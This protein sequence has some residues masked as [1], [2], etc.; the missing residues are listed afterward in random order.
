MAARAHRFE[1]EARAGGFRY[2]RFSALRMAPVS[3]ASARVVPFARPARQHGDLVRLLMGNRDFSGRHS[4]RW[5]PNQRE[6][7]MT[8]GTRV[9]WS[10]SIP[11]GVATL[12]ARAATSSLHCT[13]QSPGRWKPCASRRSDTCNLWGDGGTVGQLR[14]GTC[15]KGGDRTLFR[16]KWLHMP[17]RILL[18]MSPWLQNEY[19]NPPF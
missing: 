6:E 13:S 7:C 19:G 3:I 15:Q 10:R 11:L 18:Q 5:G 14:H 8:I 17:L 16:A 2:L 12:L 9:I 1:L 4:G